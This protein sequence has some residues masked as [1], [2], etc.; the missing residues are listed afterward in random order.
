VAADRATAAASIEPVLP[1]AGGAA[2]RLQSLARR[3][4]CPT[5]LAA[6][7]MPESGLSKAESLIDA[8]E[9][10]GILRAAWQGD[11]IR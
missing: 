7:G 5:S 9:A 8:P 2:A 10:A 6:L 3:L 4:G 1:G 11:E